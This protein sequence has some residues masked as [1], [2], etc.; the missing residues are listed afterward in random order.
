MA[1]NRISV[2][3]QDTDMGKLNLKLYKRFREEK[4]FFD[5]KIKVS[6]VKC[7]TKYHE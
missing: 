2:T 1:T 3:Y 7:L 5:V 6:S 4:R